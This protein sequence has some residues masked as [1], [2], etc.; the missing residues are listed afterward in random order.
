[1]TNNPLDIYDILNKLFPSKMGMNGRRINYSNSERL[2]DDN[3]IYYTLTLNDVE[4]KGDIKV[5]VMDRSIDIELKSRLEENDDDTIT[6]TSPKR[7]IPNKYNM[8]YVNNIL[9]I[10]LYIDKVKEEELTNESI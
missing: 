7:I 4:D 9:D 6:L 10:T 3:N 5:T 1:M 8:T 2:I